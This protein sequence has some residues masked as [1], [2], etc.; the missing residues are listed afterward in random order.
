MELVEPCVPTG[1]SYPETLAMHLESSG[2]KIVSPVK[3][4]T[5]PPS[6]LPVQKK[7]VCIK[8][9]KRESYTLTGRGQTLR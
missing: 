3:I 5:V 8:M 4:P 6:A 2:E 7:N 1:T 9:H